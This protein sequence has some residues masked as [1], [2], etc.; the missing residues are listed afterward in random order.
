MLPMFTQV[1]DAI[2]EQEKAPGIR[3]VNP[4]FPLQLQIL[5]V[6]NRTRQI[7]AD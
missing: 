6:S 4:S 5:S 3:E 1:E 2:V 7:P